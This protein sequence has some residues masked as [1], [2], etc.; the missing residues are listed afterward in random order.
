MFKVIRP[1]DMNETF[2]RAFNSR[3]L[4]NLLGLYEDNAIH[5]VD[6]SETV[7]RG[8]REISVELERLLQS[9]GSMVSVNNFCIQHEDIALLRADWVLRD[10]DK[11]IAS[12]STAEIVRRQADGSWLYIVDHAAGATLPPAIKF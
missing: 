10:A 2:A 8:K 11:I 6:G 7:F 9:P 1:S 5:K 3:R 4:E 12:G